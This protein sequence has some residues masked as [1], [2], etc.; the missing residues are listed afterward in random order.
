MDNLSRLSGT[1]LAQTRNHSR[2]ITIIKSETILGYASM[3]EWQHLMCLHIAVNTTVTLGCSNKVRPPAC[4]GLTNLGSIVP[5]QGAN[6]QA[7]VRPLRL[8]LVSCSR[9]HFVLCNGQQLVATFVAPGAE[10]VATVARTI[11]G[12]NVIAALV[13]EVWPDNSD[14]SCRYITTVIFVDP[15]APRSAADTC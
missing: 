3:T 13:E 11:A 10:T 4:L 8:S 9:L 5:V 6:D 7:V 12:G 1:S 15:S 2:L 14:D